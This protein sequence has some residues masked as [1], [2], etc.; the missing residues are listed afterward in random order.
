[1]NPYIFAS[2]SCR[3]L[4]CFD[5]KIQTD[6]GKQCNSLHHFNMEFQGGCNFLGKLHTARQHL[7]LLKFV[8]MDQSLSKDDQNRLL[9]MSTNSPWYQQYLSQD[10]DYS[11]GKSLSHIR[12]NLSKTRL[13]LFEICSLK[14]ALHKETYFPVAE[15]LEGYRTDLIRSKSKEECRKDILELI[16]YVNKKF[17]KPKI[18]LVGHIRNWIFNKRHAF[19]EDRQAIYEL[20]VEMDSLFDNVY[21]IDPAVFLTNDDMLDDWHYKPQAYSKIYKKI[22]TFF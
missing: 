4:C 2:G 15:E 21:Y 7:L 1:M 17:N 18:V 16:Y 13:F 8:M 20:L 9:S 6:V 12:E 5:N 22:C 3:L 19:I 11:Y 14:N 10:E